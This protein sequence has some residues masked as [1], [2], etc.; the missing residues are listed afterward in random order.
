MKTKMKKCKDGFAFSR[1]K[2]FAHEETMGR[3]YFKT[4]PGWNTTKF[5]I[6]QSRILKYIVYTTFHKA[7]TN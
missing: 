6:E 1:N 3:L 4:G 7:H 2:R 5:I